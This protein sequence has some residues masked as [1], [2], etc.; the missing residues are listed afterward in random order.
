MTT[1]RRDRFRS[2]HGHV[3]LLTLLPFVGT[4][5]AARLQDH[6]DEMIARLQEGFAEFRETIFQGSDQAN[7]SRMTV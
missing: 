7:G 3:R 6:L 5:P 4:M 1:P 2:D